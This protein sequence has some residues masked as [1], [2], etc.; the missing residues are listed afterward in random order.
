M[1]VYFEGNGKAQLNPLWS[2]TSSVRVATDKT[3]RPALRH[4]L[5]RP[6]AQLRQRRAD[7]P[8][9]TTSALPLAF[10]GLRQ[11]DDQK[12]IPF[13]LPA[14][15]AR[16]MI[17]T[18][19]GG[20]VEIQANNLA[21]FRSKARIRSALS[22]ALAGSSADHQL[23]PGSPAQPPTA[24]ATFITPTIAPARQ[25]SSIAVRWLAWPGDRRRRPPK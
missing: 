21:L 17:R 15:D 25:L 19:A 2:I 12:Q 8:E 4:Q 5:R 3:R 22:P 9:T 10:Q 7:Q 14:I 20:R 18:V 6:P 24:V 16:W 23:G 11:D 13:A 1:R